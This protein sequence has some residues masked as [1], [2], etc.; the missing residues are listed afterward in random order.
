MSD[1]KRF[2]F[3]GERRVGLMLETEKVL[4]DT[5]MRR[6]LGKVTVNFDWDGAEKE[7]WMEEEYEQWLVTGMEEVVVM[8]G[9][10]E[11][12]GSDEVY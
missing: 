8:E 7:V 1:F 4:R 5:R 10:E 6:P 2:A 12:W 9:Q 3:T 11:D